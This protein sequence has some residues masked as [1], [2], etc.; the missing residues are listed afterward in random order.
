MARINFRQ[1]IVRTHATALQFTAGNTVILLDGQTAP[2]VLNFADGPNDDYL[3]EEA[4]LVDPAWTD[5]PSA[6]E[7]WLYIDID[8]MT[9]ERTFGTTIYQPLDQ[10]NTPSNPAVGQHWFDTRSTQTVM[11]VW[12][13]SRWTEK[14]RMFV[15]K[16]S[17]LTIFPYSTGT[18]AGLNDS[19]LSGRILYDDE[20]RT[21]PIKKYDRRGQGKF[22]TTESVI[23][24]QFSN[25]T[26]FKVAQGLVEGQAIENIPQYYAVALRGGEYKI[27]LA[28]NGTSGGAQ[29]G[30]YPA[31]G[32]ATE[33]FVTGETHTYA[34]NGYITDDNFNWIE[35]P[36]TYIFVGP[37][38]QLTT[39]VPQSGS[40]QRVGVVIN[41]YTIQ[42]DIQPIII[43]G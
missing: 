40:L 7:Y 30:P 42:I 6:N 2:V 32:I 8:K 17:G 24:S 39:S 38:G 19:V 43:Y 33:D 21:Q 36:G 15:A 23:F 10:P 22:I 11:K 25:I 9:A 37:T 14:V 26:G 27:G 18:Q 3:W 29:P 16:V 34:A 13:G 20:N 12:A 41:T 1:G 31:I 4:L 5:L 35:D 28:K